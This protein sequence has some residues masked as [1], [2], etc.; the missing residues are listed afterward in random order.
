MSR[1]KTSVKQM[2]TYLTCDFSGHKMEG[3]VGFMYQSW[4]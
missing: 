1:L 2:L 4:K 3:Q